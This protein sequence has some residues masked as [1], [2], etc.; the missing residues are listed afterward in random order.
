MSDNFLINCLLVLIA[1]YVGNCLFYGSLAYNK[2]YP[3]FKRAKEAGYLDELMPPI[4]YIFGGFALTS[5]IIR[6]I[7]INIETINQENIY[8]QEILDHRNKSKKRNIWLL[9]F[10]ILFSVS[11]FNMVYIPD[12]CTYGNSFKFNFFQK[13][14]CNMFKND[15]GLF[16][17]ISITLALIPWVLVFVPA[18]FAMKVAK[19]E[20][21][22][23]N[24]IEVNVD[25]KLKAR[26]ILASH[27]IN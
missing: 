1:G 4:V 9:I 20:K 14:I 15:Y 12:M 16:E 6:K 22:L 17:N 26:D 13:Q 18:F 8:D 25:E 7:V 24:Y 11:L 2:Y 21:K 5:N 19:I 23:L 3:L 27:Q 10:I